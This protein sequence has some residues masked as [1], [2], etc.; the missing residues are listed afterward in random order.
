VEEAQ[1]GL[2]E[3]QRLSHLLSTPWQ[4]R[5]AYLSSK[6]EVSHLITFT[7]WTMLGAS[8]LGMSQTGGS[9]CWIKYQWLLGEIEG[10]NIQPHF[11]N[12]AI[13][14]QESIQL[15]F[16]FCLNRL[17]P[18]CKIRNFVINIYI[19]FKFGETTPVF[20]CVL[21]FLYKP[22]TSNII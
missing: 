6:Q 10:E 1:Q 21:L 17:C 11:N 12:L 9:D 8:W 3:C 13:C 16:F 22:M 15:L 19:Y 7:K 20:V 14:F 5:C 4:N 2:H 18:N